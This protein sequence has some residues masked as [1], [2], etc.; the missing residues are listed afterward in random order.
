MN[1]WDVFYVTLSKVSNQVVLKKWK[2]H[3]F[4]SPI[5]RLTYYVD[6][7]NRYFPGYKEHII[8][9]QS[10]PNKPGLLKAKPFTKTTR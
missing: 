10:I 3:V 7:L 5:G 1:T 8:Q 4:F 2:E 9:L 6:W